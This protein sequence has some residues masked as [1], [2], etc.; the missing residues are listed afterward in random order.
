[1]HL[2]VYPAFE[3]RC[4]TSADASS[5]ARRI[6]GPLAQPNSSLRTACRA[7]PCGDSTCPILAS[8]RI[9]KSG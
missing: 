8:S 3:F 6:Y 2:V 4:H 1:M 9:S 7:L 5:C